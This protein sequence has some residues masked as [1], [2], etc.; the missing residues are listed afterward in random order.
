VQTAVYRAE[1]L[2]RQFDA[3]ESD[4]EAMFGLTGAAMQ[5]ERDV[6]A[7]A[8]ALETGDEASSTENGV[9]VVSAGETLDVIALQV[10]GD[11]AVADDIAALNGLQ[12]PYISLTGIPGTAGPG[13]VLLLPPGAINPPAFPEASAAVDALLYGVDFA[14]ETQGQWAGDFATSGSDPDDIDLISGVPLVVQDLNLRVNTTAGEDPDNPAD[15]LPVQI[16]APIYN[17]AALLLALTRE[18]LLRDDRLVSVQGM[19]VALTGLSVDVQATGVLRSGRAI[20][21]QS[22]TGVGE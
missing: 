22:T 2:A 20:A 14:L 5:L 6:E 15:G 13:D 18:Q 1:H 9:Y 10:Y 17:E 3:V 19:D 7:M 21:L 4:Y 8:F 12:P 16:G 11:S